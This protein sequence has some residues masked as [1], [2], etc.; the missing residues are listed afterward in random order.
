M[1]DVARDAKVSRALVS[2]VMREQPNVSEARRQRVLEAASRLG[3]RPNAM[4][5]GLASRRTRTVGVILDDLR[6]PFFAEIAGGVEEL[7]S[8][9]GYQLLLGAGGRQARRE[10][11]ALNALLEY[12]VD[13]IILVSPR[14]T[15]AHLAAAVAG[16]PLVVVGRQLRSTDADFVLTDEAHGTELVLEHLTGLGHEQIAHVDGGRGAGGPQR[17]AAYL[18]GMKA[19]RLARYARVIPGDFTEEA[20]TRAAQELL[21]EPR[22]PTAVFAANDVIAAGLLGGFDRAGITVPGEVSIVGYDNI[23][24]AHL[25]HVSLTTIDQPRTSMGRIALE[26]LLDR[27]EHRRAG[28][29]RLLEPTLVVRSTTGPPRASA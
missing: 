26:L 1:E 10:R 8:D 6:N 17:R 3:Y 25:A 24:I 5:R 7:A 11:I 28:V 16:V 23:S 9:L 27:I 18:R 22:L 2:L 12:R 20:G 19:R 15:A 21:R 4:A 29:L 13:G 14:M